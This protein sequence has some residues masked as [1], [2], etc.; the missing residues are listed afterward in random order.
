MGDTNTASANQGA[1]ID[2]S[3][4]Y[5][6]FFEE[7]GENLD[8]M[9]QQLLAIDV[10]AADDEELNAIFRCAHSI[11]GGAATFGF[12]DVAELTHQMETLLDKLRRH[13]LQPTAA[14]V[15][16]L[17]QSGDA[18]RSQLARHQG[19][20]GEVLDTSELLTSI[21]AFVGGQA[22]VPAAKAAPAAVVAAPAPAP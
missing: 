13:E 12:A 3:Q 16:V 7:A 8:R 10:A 22:P 11:K 14:M 2:L 5:Q 18:L 17:L 21:R 4:F 1:G 20:G 9:E 6:V 19:A 15:D